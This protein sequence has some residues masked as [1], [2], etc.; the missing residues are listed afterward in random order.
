MPFIRFL[1]TAFRF[2]H[3]LMEYFKVRRKTSPGSYDSTQKTDK[4]SS[5]RQLEK[6]SFKGTLINARRFMDI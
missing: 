2:G 5:V 4:I 6:V 1:I 3:S